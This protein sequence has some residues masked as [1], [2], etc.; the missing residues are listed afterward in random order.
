MH[1]LLS[2]TAE[3]YQRLTI[4]VNRNKN[5]RVSVFDKRLL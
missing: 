1:N 3:Q 5:N 2:H 4:N